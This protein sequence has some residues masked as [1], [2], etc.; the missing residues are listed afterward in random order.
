M[1]FSQ[2][3]SGLN[4]SSQ[5]LDVVGNNI[6]NSQTVGFKSG[7]VAFADVFAGS[8][9]GMG[10][11]VAGV[12]QNFS[13]GVLGAGSSPLDMGIQGNGFFRMVTEAG[14]VFYSRNGQFQSDENGYVVN[15]QGMRLTGYMAT[16]TPPAIQQGAPVGPIQIPTGQMPARASDAGS[17]SGNL[18]SGNDVVTV[19]PFDP[20]DGKSY[21]Y[22]TQVNAYDSLGNEHAINVYYVKTADNQ[23]TAY[24]VDSTSPGTTSSVNLTFDTSGKLTTNPANLPVV[25]AAYQGG[26]ALNFNL[27]LSGLS[28]QASENTMDS[29]STTGYPPGLMN[30]YTVGDNGQIIASYSNGENQLLGQVVLSNFTN[31][32]GLQSAGNNCWTETPESGQPVIGIADTGNLG[33]LRGNMLEASNVDLSKEMVNMIVYQRNYQSN[34]Q[35]IKTQSELLQTLVNL[36]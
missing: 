13:D 3:L 1:G 22:S 32:G 34:S 27:D 25:G 12:N 4:A 35:T 17:I 23:W 5:A 18:N 15:N 19:T 29:P 26:A 8:Q 2:G 14:R 33:S 28:Q 11:Q 16:G 31:P 7:S 36:G 10:V 21:S 30:G 20:A 9:V 6:A 24:S